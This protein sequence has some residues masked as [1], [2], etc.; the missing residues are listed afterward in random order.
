MG[1]EASKCICEWSSRCHGT[2]FRT[3][4][5]CDGQYGECVCGCDNIA[6][7][8]A[9]CDDCVDEDEELDDC[10]DS[11]AALPWCAG[12]ADCECHRSDAH[13]LDEASDGGQP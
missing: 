2:G 6:H 8:C 9:G 7:D 11:C 4:R 12:P 13:G 10:C 1:S 5:G 3:C